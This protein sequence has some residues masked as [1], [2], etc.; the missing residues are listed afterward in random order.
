[1]K[2]NRFTET[3]SVM[4]ADSEIT[5]L[6]TVLLV[7]FVK[8]RAGSVCVKMIKSRKISRHRRKEL[9]KLRHVSNLLKFRSFFCLLI[10]SDH[11][12]QQNTGVVFGREYHSKK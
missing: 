10:N 5:Q 4:F 9:G 6:E 1:M 7:R 3:R 8:N 2:I 12:T 11:I